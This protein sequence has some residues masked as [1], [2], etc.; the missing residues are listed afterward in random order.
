MRRAMI[1]FG[2][3]LGTTNSTIAVVHGIDAQ[4]ISNQAGSALTPSA[5]W[6]NRRNQLLV[7]HEPK[8]RALVDDPDNADL[9]F[10]LR[11]GQP[12][13][14]KLFPRD[15]RTRSPEELSSEVLKQL[16]SD[17]RTAMGEDIEAA[18]IT[19]PAAFENP[20]TAATIRAAR[21]AGLTLTPLLLEPV[22]A[23]LAYGLQS[24]ND[25]IFWLVYDF[26]GGTF[27][28]AVMRIRD[29]MI[30]VENH[31]GDNYL[32]GKLLDWDIVT[33][34]LIPAA[35][36]QFDLPQLAREN[37][38]AREA[39]GKLKYNAEIAKIEVCRTR[40]PKEIFIENWTTDANGKTVD[41]LYTL[42]PAE[43]EKIS[44]PYIVRS[45][46]LCLK[47]IKDA[48]LPT[49]ALE[50]VL[51]VG[52]STLNPWIRDAVA[53]E[54]GVP[55]DFGID[56]VTVVARGAAIFAST[57]ENKAGGQREA[58]AAGQWEITLEYQLAGNVPD[59]DVGG[60]VVPPAGTTPNGCTIELTDQTT[61]WRSGK[62]ALG[63]DGVFIT[64]LYAGT[65]G[66]HDY[67]IE[68][69]DPVGTRLPTTPASMPYTF[70][71]VIPDRPP[72]AH[73][74]S[75]GLNNGDVAVYVK[76]GSPLPARKMLD[77][78]SAVHVRAG[79]ADESLR[80]PVLE[81]ENPRARRNHGIGEMRITGD[82]LRRD[83]TPGSQ[84]EITVVMDQ[85]QQITCKAFIPALE[86]DF[87]NIVF[88]PVS[89]QGTVE[90]LL[91]EVAREKAR[92][93]KARD[94]ALRI[95]A[96]GADA[97]LARVNQ[98]QLLEQIDALARAAAADPEARGQLDRR[99]K[100][101]AAIVDQLE[102]A[103]EWP[104]LVEDSRESQAD[105]MRVVGDS[106]NEEERRL[107]QK[108]ESDLDKAVAAGDAYQLRRTKNEL[109]ILY[110][111]VVDRQP[112]YQLARF[113]HLSGQKSGMT[114]Q[115][116]AEQV[117]V[118]GQRAIQN[119]DIPALKA[120][121]RQL[122]LLLPRA[123]AA[124]SRDWREGDTFAAIER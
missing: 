122:I 85:S 103:I 3:D 96:E 11:M 9:E 47:T 74:I 35:R 37:A 111:A 54:V 48:K 15:G 113:R 23:S 80:I 43:V 106:G 4:T 5:V 40:S 44:R 7:G 83:L 98:E 32:G 117:I 109:D 97:L 99:L 22:A 59:P 17:V 118:Q 120:A 52:G 12:G 38:A 115:A 51:M 14:E 60:R 26:G 25:N 81:G 100:E 65:E 46:N 110:F 69:C 108:L 10:K 87:E 77:H 86:Q 29:G 24:A 95:R 45:L 49:T 90:K 71:K 58:V 28:A 8:Q 101:L 1:D 20:A 75:V 21:L 61:R 93:D 79:R 121:N 6:I 31:E 68:L 88:E 89:Q 119:N 19:V 30:H 36:A 50:R 70:R 116:Q 55:L 82:K 33:Q 64:Q 114:D 63:G 2:I 94:E 104:K 105:T 34:L 39:V 18:V 27:D 107:L 57:V 91:E 42:T 72:A 102:D 112:S 41:F 84:V 16:R 62:I 13:G 124:A 123:A 92:L 56:P 78:V 67:A 76:K 73:T 53:A 66:R